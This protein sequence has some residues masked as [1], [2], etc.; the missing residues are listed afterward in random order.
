MT[1]NQKP[2]QTPPRNGDKNQNNPDPNDRFRQA[3]NRS[4]IWIIIAVVIFFGYRMLAN[5]QVNPDDVIGLNG[6]AEAIQTNQ[7]KKIV[8]QGDEVIVTL[9][10]SKRLQSRKESGVS[11]LDSLSAFGVT[12][13][14]LAN[15]PISVEKPSNSS[16]IFSWLVMLLPMLLIF[17]F[18]IFIMR[19]TGG[20]GQNRAMQ[21][22]RSR[23]RKLDEA[24]RPT[25][26]FE[27][28]AGSD[29]AKQELQEI[30]EFLREPQKFAALGA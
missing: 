25:I 23:A 21:F 14:Q 20:A 4:W 30:V 15:L 11:L 5:P 24:D 28:V 26:T 27:D 7:V 17:G 13:A 18:F 29:E 19:Q 10:N 1:E 2:Q 9:N 16:T 22:G 6:M 8:V 3:F 12:E